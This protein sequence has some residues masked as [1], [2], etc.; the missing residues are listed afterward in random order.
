ML[1]QKKLDSWNW[2][3]IWLCRDLYFSKIEN[4]YII[5]LIIKTLGIPYKYTFENIPEFLVF[6]F[7]GLNNL[8]LNKSFL[9]KKDGIQYLFKLKGIVYFSHNHFTSRINNYTEWSNMVPW[10]YDP[11]TF[12]E[13]WRH[14]RHKIMPRYILFKWWKCYTSHL[15]SIIQI[16]KLINTFHIT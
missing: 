1:P 7:G 13:V 5:H 3:W 10:W 8:K 6:D 4:E 16:D 12:N 2:F 9:L 11:T 14:V 15:Y